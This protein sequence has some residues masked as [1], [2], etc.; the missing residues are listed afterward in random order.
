MATTK[1]SAAPLASDL[2]VVLGQLIRRLRSEHRFSLSQGSV[3]GRLDREGACSVSDLAFAERVR[4]QS[5]A[6]TVTDLES[7]GL[8]ARAPDPSD[9]RRALVS[10]TAAGLTELREDRLRREG[11]LVRAIE[12]LPAADQVTVERAIVLLRQLADA[13]V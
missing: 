2:R 8:V 3:L 11:W 9:G 1:A 12:E 6:Q 4:P 7:D 5:M 13:E 10:L